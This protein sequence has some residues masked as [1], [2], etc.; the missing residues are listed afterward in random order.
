M[1]PTFFA[2]A[3]EFRAWLVAHHVTATALLVGFHKAGTGVPSMTWTESV[4]EA[5][6]FGWID[7]V[8]RRIDDATYS[9]R[10]TPRKPGS[11]WS[12]VNV[13]HAEELIAA[14]RMLPAGHAAFEARQAHKVGVYSFE[15][16]AVELPATYRATFARH[17]SAFAWFEA[18]A[19]SYRKAAVWWVITAKQEATRRRRLETL[20]ACSANAE[21][22]P[23]MRPSR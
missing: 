2:S 15:Q 5:L 8:R 18:Q 4:R 22:L 14:G 1:T 21:R 17:A 10:F 20:I 16:G 7:G 3:T 13:R 11:I 9:I 12:A 6:C 19:P 23:Q